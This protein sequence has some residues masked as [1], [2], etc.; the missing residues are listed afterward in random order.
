MCSG[1]IGRL[2]FVLMFWAAPSRSYC[3]ATIEDRPGDSQFWT[4]LMSALLSISA[5]SGF[6][7]LDEG[8]CV[9][10]LVSGVG[11]VVRRESIAT[12]PPRRPPI[13]GRNKVSNW[14][15]PGTKPWPKAASVEMGLYSFQ[16]CV[17]DVLTD[18][19]LAKTTVP[20]RIS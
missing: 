17:A 1:C 5:Q 7:A 2:C 10:S 14:P 11:N 3:G 18:P 8:G 13:S 6:S 9:I 15:P 20:S 16:P 4:L 12:S 19:S